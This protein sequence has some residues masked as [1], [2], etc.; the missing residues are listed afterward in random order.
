MTNLFTNL[1]KNGS[2]PV[3]GPRMDRHYTENGPIHSRQLFAVLVM[4]CFGMGQMWGTSVTYTQSST[5]AISATSGTAPTSSSVSFST[6]YTDKNQLTSG[7]IQ[8]LTLSSCGNI[9]ITNIT[10]S[11]KSN[12]DSGAGKL[13]YSVDGGTTWTYL[14]GS[15]TTGSKFNTSSWYGSWSTSYV[16]V[17]K[18]VGIVTSSGVTNGFILKIESTANSIFCQSFTLTYN[19]EKFTVTYNGGSGTPGKASETQS[20]VGGALTLPSATPSSD[21]GAAGWELA[22]WKKTSGVASVTTHEPT[23]YT[24]S[25]SYYPGATETLYA[26]YLL[27]TERTSCTAGKITSTAGLSVGDCVVLISEGSTAQY[28]G[29]N[30]NT[31]GTQTSY[32]TTPA[33]IHL[34]DVEEGNSSGQVAFYDRTDKNYL[35]LTSDG[36]A[37][38]TKTSI[39]A[40]SSWTV[41]ISD[42]TATITNAQ[43]TTRYIQ[44]NSGSS[45]KRFAC[46]TSNQAAVQLY[47]VCAPI[48]AYHSSPDC[49]VDHFIDIMHDKVVADQSGTY[50]MPAITGGDATPGSTYCDE[51]HYHF[52]GWVEDSDINDDGS[53][54][55][56]YT[57]Y[58]AGD[59]NSGAGYTA[60]NKTFYAIW[61]KEE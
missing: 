1:S 46:Y 32:T 10:L 14:V 53:L 58:P 7:K 27:S 18:D 49:T 9:A 25:S 11:M 38:Y 30:G 8:T 5:T 19:T 35:A 4:L 15:S 21:C 17:S 40:Y 20:T 60:A 37:L 45:P 41:T 28:N 51:K 34:L 61:A 54:K 26:V 55:D 56:G 43:Y 42:G 24:A 6:T 50:T 23:L 52:L 47:K 16:N 44:F 12:S 3:N 36:N 33:S 59:D 48:L 39:D 29:L 22:G 13:Y 31:Y 57:L 2:E